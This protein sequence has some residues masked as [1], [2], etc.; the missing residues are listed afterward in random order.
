MEL[1][2]LPV[3]ALLWDSP[4][5]LWTGLEGVLLLRYP[6]GTG[7]SGGAQAQGTHQLTRAAFRQT[8]EET[9]S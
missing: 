2:P 5:A 6:R 9:G 7:G 4:L 3:G 8:L 1:P